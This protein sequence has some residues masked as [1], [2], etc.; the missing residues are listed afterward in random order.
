MRTLSA[1]QGDGSTVAASPQKGQG[2]SGPTTARGRGM[3]LSSTIMLVRSSCGA[4]GSAR[5][6]GDGAADGLGA[7]LWLFPVLLPAQRGLV[8]H[9][10]RPADGLQ[11][12][13]V[14]G[15]GVV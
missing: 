8:E 14:D 15:V 12:A 2:R 9:V 4:G 10:V 1:S 5:E 7:A 11:P 13:R 3:V 6:I